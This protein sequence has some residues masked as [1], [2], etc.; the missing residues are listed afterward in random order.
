MVLEEER[1]HVLHEMNIDINSIMEPSILVHLKQKIFEKL[2]RIGRSNG[3]VKEWTGKFMTAS[4]DGF[5][6]ENGK[7]RY[8]GFPGMHSICRNL[9]HHENIKVKLQ[10]RANASYND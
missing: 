1:L 4:A 5:V 2:F 6:E 3:W 7:E 8:V 10:T 9:L